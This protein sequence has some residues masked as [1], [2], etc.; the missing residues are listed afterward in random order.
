MKEPGWACAGNLLNPAPARARPA[1]R[2][3][4]PRIRF[5]HRLDFHMALLN[6][7]D[8]ILCARCVERFSWPHQIDGPRTRFT[9]RIHIQDSPCSRKI[10]HE[11]PH[12]ATISKSAPEYKHDPQPQQNSPD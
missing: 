2:F 5:E 4:K 11:N 6:L 9:P 8:A 1:R 7:A 10:P 3:G 12:A